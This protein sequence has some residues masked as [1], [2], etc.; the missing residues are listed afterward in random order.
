MGVNRDDV[1]DV[2]S[3]D[4]CDDALYVFA[5]IACVYFDLLVV[6]SILLYCWL[7]CTGQLSPGEEPN[8]ADVCV[9]LIYIDVP[10]CC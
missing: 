2:C 10:V 4:E 6:L 3:Y 1:H 5:F 7:L 9:I 8:C